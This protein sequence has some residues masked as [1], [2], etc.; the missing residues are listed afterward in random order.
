MRSIK[1]CHLQWLWVSSKRFS[2]LWYF[3]NTN[4]SKWYV[5]FIDKLTMDANRKLNA[6]Y[7]MVQVLMTFS[8]TPGLGF[9]FKV[10]IKNVQDRAIVTTVQLTERHMCN[11]LNGVISY[12]IEWPLTWV[13]RSWYFSKVNISKG[14]IWQCQTAD[15]SLQLLNLLFNVQLGSV[16]ICWNPIRWNPNPKP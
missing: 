3:S 1:W 15:N 8:V 5:H 11:L 2:M 12:D 7:Q 4:S 10:P 14:C 9:H 13:S 6:S 16:P